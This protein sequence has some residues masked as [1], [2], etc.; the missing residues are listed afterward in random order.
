LKEIPTNAT[1]RNYQYQYW[2]AK[3]DLTKTPFLDTY[4]STDERLTI[5]FANF[6]ELHFDV[7]PHL[8]FFLGDV[9]MF[10]HVS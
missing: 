9:M 7:S 3:K 5:S 6:H 8:A 4:E 2:F 10:L 1:N